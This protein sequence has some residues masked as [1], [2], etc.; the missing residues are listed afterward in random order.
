[1]K[2]RI[3]LNAIFPGEPIGYKRVEWRGKRARVPELMRKTQER[4]RTALKKI[5]PDL[6]PTNARLG[7]QLVFHIG[8]L[9]SKFHEPD[10][11]NLEKLFWD[12]F[13]G[14][15]WD[16]D[17]QIEEWTGWKVLNSADPRTHAVVYVIE[18]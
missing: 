16:D 8:P 4:L 3:I 11:D 18:R 5:A 10:G 12:A 2:R 7:L 15:I 14:V 1:V 13:N 6:K 17:A 9:C